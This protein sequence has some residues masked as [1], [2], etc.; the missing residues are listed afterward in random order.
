MR[1]NDDYLH[2]Y[3]FY[4]ATATNIG[5]FVVILSYLFTPELRYNPSVLIFY[6]SIVDWGLGF[7][8]MFLWTVD[9]FTATHRSYDSYCTFIGPIT[10]F[11]FFCSIGYFIALVT[12]LYTAIKNPFCSPNDTNIMCT[13]GIILFT[14]AMIVVVLHYTTAAPFTY[15]THIQLCM[16]S[17]YTYSI[18]LLLSALYGIFVTISA[19]CRLRKGL[20]NTFN[21]RRSVIVNAWSYCIVFVG[22]ILIITTSYIFIFIH[23]HTDAWSKAFAISVGNVGCVD[24]VVFIIINYDTFAQWIPCQCCWD[25]AARNTYNQLDSDA[26]TTTTTEQKDLLVP[27]HPEQVALCN[28]LTPY[29][30]TKKG[31]LSNTETRTN[32]EPKQMKQSCLSQCCKRLGISVIKQKKTINEA[33]RREILAYTT[34]GIAQ[35]AD[36]INMSYVM[37]LNSYPRTIGDVRVNV[38]NAFHVTIQNNWALTVKQRTF[39]Q[40]SIRMN[41]CCCIRDAGYLVYDDDKYSK[42]REFVDYAPLIFRYIRNNVIGITGIEYKASIISS[43]AKTQLKVLKKCTFGEG[44]SGAFFYVTHDSKFIVKTIKKS[45]VKVL[46]LIL[47]DYVH[48]LEQNPQTILARF[49]GLHSI[50]IYGVTAYFVVMENVFAARLKPTEMY[51][52]KGSW[53]G[54]VTAHGL[55]DGSTMKDSD[56]KRHIILNDE[57]RRAVLHQLSRDTQFL[58]IYY[59][60]IIDALQSYSWRKRLERWMKIHIMRMDAKGIMRRLI[61]LSTTTTT[62]Q[63]TANTIQNGFRCPQDCKCSLIIHTHWYIFYFNMFS[64]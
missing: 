48:Y 19:F 8:V 51:D 43:T 36:N 23:P 22:Y 41:V 46:I 34:D 37:T 9:T 35:A 20:P 38:I 5:S 63:S 7:C 21:I 54:R 47:K 30:A 55:L 40:D 10:Q 64:D 42:Q 29:T 28:S 24:F 33:L 49:V 1:T 6:R 58:S 62:H 60:G 56:L 11:L 2:Q 61:G 57:Q 32:V 53:V 45:E 16:A 50:K 15:A 13:N 26:T 3:Y 18:P 39:E 12:S 17:V 25:D 59:F 52:L 31:I 44:Q 27:L 14:A 4:G